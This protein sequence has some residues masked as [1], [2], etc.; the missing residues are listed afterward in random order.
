MVWRPKKKPVL[1]VVWLVIALLV[2]AGVMAYLFWPVSFSEPP[3]P[4]LAPGAVSEPVVSPPPV[5]VIEEPTPTIDDESFDQPL[6]ATGNEAPLV[7]VPDQSVRETLLTPADSQ[8]RV[9]HL[10]ELPL[11]FQKSV[12]DLTFNSHIYS[13]D[14]TASRVMINNHY[15]RPGDAFGDL[16]V[17]RVTDDGVIMSRGSQRFRVGTVRDWVSP[18]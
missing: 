18:R 14:P 3:V 5:V 9:P 17:E 1:P 8:G 7:I 10:V 6:A 13:S 15:L 16:T 11:S 12:P 2:N 4:E